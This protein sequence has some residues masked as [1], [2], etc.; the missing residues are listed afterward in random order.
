MTPVSDSVE[1]G[2]VSRLAR[3]ARRWTGLAADLPAA[4]RPLLVL[5]GFVAIVRGLLPVVF[6]V[7][8]GYVLRDVVGS[9]DAL[10][11]AGFGLVMA[12]AAFALQQ[13]F[14]PLQTVLT[15]LIGRRVDGAGIRHL[16]SAAIRA[17]LSYTERQE[18][19]T[20]LT[21]TTVNFLYIGL[22][23]G[24]A[25]AALFPLATRYLDLT[26]AV[27][28]IGLATSWPVAVLLGAAALTIR[29]AQRGSL[30]RFSRLW[31]GLAGDRQKIFYLQTIGTHDASAK[32]M[33]ALR[34]APWLTERH[35]R[36][37]A[38][39]FR[40]LWQGRRSIYFAPFIGY[41]VLGYL[42]AVLAFAAIAFESSG[43]HRVLG[44]AV[45][46]QAVLVPLRFGAHFPDCDTATQYGSQAAAEL[47]R[48]HDDLRTERGAGGGAPVR[49]TGP[50][51]VRFDDVA[52]RY[53]S[54]SAAV[55]DGLDLV[56]PAGTSTAVVGV[57]GAGKTTLVKQLCGLYAPD[58]G[59]ITVDGQ[60]L[61]DID[62]AAWRA[63]VAVILQDFVRYETTLRDNVIFGAPHHPVDED[64]LADAIDRAR[65]GDIVADL[66]HGL[67]T[68]LSPAYEGG[69]GL[70]G[71]QWQRLALARALY[72]VN[73][74][75]RLLVL[76]E[77]TAQLDVRSEAA[78][79]ER[80]IDLT[81]G[82]TTLVISHRFSTVRRADA[83]AVL[84][85]GRVEE[86]G[87]HDELLA[88]DRTYARMFRLQADRFVDQAPAGGDGRP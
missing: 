67:D 44:L 11:T 42:I 60:D 88:A 68:M 82:V 12:F 35:G 27:V 41:S 85:D 63:H 76:D 7:S 87:T 29:F 8:M 46:V 57:N 24:K 75:A 56:L 16:M 30:G 79:F 15:D 66:P 18:S 28:V 5:A 52:F 80:F 17:P 2:P 31:A 72:A 86:Y 48:L 26:A 84:A 77:P 22:T 6:I 33:R 40:P 65:A 38:A 21:N 45:A 54:G 51:T 36:D 25:A 50:P 78:F 14:A 3:R 61:R 81:D 83:I 1:R 20:A 55:L 58:R 49:L 39:Y 10:R 32:E 59:R 9:A 62:P 23:P 34:L 71:G 43:Q 4:G 47:R 53:P 64:A 73:T 70:S 13:L 19:I 74:G 69:V 37:N